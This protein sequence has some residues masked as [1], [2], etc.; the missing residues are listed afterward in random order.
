MRLPLTLVVALAGAGLP[1]C[2][3]HTATPPAPPAIV[4]APPDETLSR[5]VDRLLDDAALAHALISVRVESLRDG[6]LLYS[7]NSDTRMIPASSLKI[8]TAAVAGERLG[9]THRFETRLDAVGRVQ[10]GVLD[11]DLVVVGSGDPAIMADGMRAAPLFDEWAALLQQAGIT[12]VD[13]RLIGD[14]TAFDDEPLGAGWAWDYLTAAYAAPSGALSYNENLV[15]VQVTPGASAGVPASVTLG[16]AGH[17]LAVDN[18]VVTAAPDAAPSIVFDRLPG[19]AALTVRGQV[20]ADGGTQLRA[21]TV[22]NPTAFFVEGL[23]VALAARG[24]T[25]TGGAWD[26]DDVVAVATDQAPRR[27][28]AIHRSA[29]VS[30]LV[31]QMMKLSRNYYGEM[32]IKAIGRLDGQPGSTESGRQIVREA[33]EAW[34]LP[35][36]ELVMYD[37]SGLSRYNYVT[38]DLL[39][40]VLRH[41]WQSEAMRGPFAAALPVAGHDG[42]LGSRMNAALRRR[43]QAKTGTIANVRALAGF[44]ESAD[45]E[46]LAFAMIANHFTAP[47]ADVDAVMERVLA[48]IL[49]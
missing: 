36:D 43:V 29:P 5:D 27:A 17:G 21:T 19:S 7:R 22:E 14:D 9:W 32:L 41:A 46:K 35:I 34:Q 20:P 48:R 13:G 4:V 1:A 15:Q 24:I 33:L 18:H 25:V 49:R 23:R 6:R 37:G 8:I 38:A 44:A 26:I 2:A 47:N 16:P 42:T 30:S 11:G 28:I 3:A 12:R 39:V 45:G 31:A 10:N 40:G